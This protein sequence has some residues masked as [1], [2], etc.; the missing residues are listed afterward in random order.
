MGAA[1]I[2]IKDGGYQ[3]ECQMD[4]GVVKSF[5]VCGSKVFVS[6]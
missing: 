1:I 6:K 2:A 3:L 4:E 5:F